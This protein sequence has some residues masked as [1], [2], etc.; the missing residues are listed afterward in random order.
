MDEII[1]KDKRTIYGF[2]E[3]QCF[4]RS[5]SIYQGF[6]R[7]MQPWM[8]IVGKSTHGTP[9]K[10][11]FPASHLLLVPVDE[12]IEIHVL[13]RH[14]NK[15]CED[16]LADCPQ[17]V[18]KLIAFVFPPSSSWLSLADH[19]VRVMALSLP[20][21]IKNITLI[22]TSFRCSLVNKVRSALCSYSS[23][24][25][26]TWF[27]LAQTAQRSPNTSV[28]HRVMSSGPDEMEPDAWPSTKLHGL[29][30]TSGI[31]I[32]LLTLCAMNWSEG[33]WNNRQVS[34]I[35]RTKSQHLK[36]SRT[37][38]RLSLPNLLKPDV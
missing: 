27:V 34:N 35:R 37:V 21:V 26:P 9:Q 32:C 25:L 11:L 13:W 10:L 22:F 5:G 8:K 7:V 29:T 12:S 1:T 36:D 23:C 3:Q 28:P 15:C 24:S 6:A 2:L 18:S 16:N 17:N 38:L 14:A 4:V 20:Q 33:T 31:V 30:S 19:M